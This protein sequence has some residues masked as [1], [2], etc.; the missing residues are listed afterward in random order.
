MDFDRMLR[1]CVLLECNN[2]RH[3]FHEPE[4]HALYV[5]AKED[6]TEL[7]LDLKF[8]LS[9]VVSPDLAERL[10]FADPK[11][12]QYRVPR[13]MRGR[14]G[15]PPYNPRWAAD[16]SADRHSLLPLGYYVHIQ[17]GG[18]TMFGTGAWCWEPEMLLRI[19]TAIS[20]Q[21]LRF[22]DALEQSGAPL[23]GDR[24]K[25]IP[26]GFDEADPAAEY[27]KYKSW[28]V[29]RAFADGELR[30]FDGFVSDCVAAA[31]RMEPLRVF[32]NDALAGIHR[33]PLET[34]D[35]DAR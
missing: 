14:H 31:E 18:R 22:S 16:V 7:L 4:N 11:A 15:V 29:S 30:S 34:S 12:M 1:Y 10:L 3:W 17:P 25:R 24:L 28:L 23:L 2:D 33:N 35:W 21:F 5:S 20:T 32:F 27:L 8:R 26:R 6:F 19:R 9:E 13:D